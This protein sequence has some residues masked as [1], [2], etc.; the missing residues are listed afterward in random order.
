MNKLIYNELAICHREN[1]KAKEITRSSRTHSSR[2]LSLVVSDLRPEA[3][4][5]RFESGC[6]LCTEESPP[7]AI[8]RP[9]PKVP[10]M[11][12]EVVERS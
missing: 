2:A 5:S 12:V 9:M 10:A 3:K 6:Q 4:D 7:A 8:A 1:E 11:S